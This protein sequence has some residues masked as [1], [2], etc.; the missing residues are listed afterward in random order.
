MTGKLVPIVGREMLWCIN[1]SN[2]IG[3]CSVEH[4]ICTITSNLGQSCINPSHIVM[5][6]VTF[7]SCVIVIENP[8]VR[9]HSSRNSGSATCPIIQ[10]VSVEEMNIQR[11]I[12]MITGVAWVTVIRSMNCGKATTTARTTLITRG[13]VEVSPAPRSLPRTVMLI[14][15]TLAA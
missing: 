2:N 5:V 10:G 9:N 12:T 11:H 7:P 6:E 4:R 3:S 13:K 15:Q 8:A 14:G 1:S